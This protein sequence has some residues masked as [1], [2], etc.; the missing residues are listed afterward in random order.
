MAS[1]H[2]TSQFILLVSSKGN[3][4][5]HRHN[6]LVHEVH[7]LGDLDYD[8]GTFD[9]IQLR[10]PVSHEIWPRALKEMVRITKPGGCIQTIEFKIKV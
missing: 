9:F 8:D 5:I 1:Q 3:W 4:T 10:R 2:P 6:V 7:D